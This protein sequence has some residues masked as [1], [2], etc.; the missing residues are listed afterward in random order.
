VLEA[1]K[2]LAVKKVKIDENI[3]REMVRAYK[4]GRSLEHAL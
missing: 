1:V 4:E 3:L 2:A